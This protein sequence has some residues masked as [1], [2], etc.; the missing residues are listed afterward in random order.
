MRL[1]RSLAIDSMG[2][3]S[4][5]FTDWPQ[6]GGEL[7]LEFHGQ[8]GIVGNARNELRVTYTY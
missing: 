5:G 7:E 2:S 1:G 4:G 3:W 6:D 8:R